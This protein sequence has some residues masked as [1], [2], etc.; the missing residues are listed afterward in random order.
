MRFWAT[1]TARLFLFFAICG[2]ATTAAAQHFEA[3]FTGQGQGPVPLRDIREIA[4]D[5]LNIDVVEIKDPEAV[6]ENEGFRVYAPG[7]VHFGQVHL[8]ADLAS[9]SGGLLSAWWAE[10]VSGKNIRKN[11][12]VTLFRK[13]GTPTRAFELSSLFPETAELPE[14]AA[15]SDCPQEIVLHCSMRGVSLAYLGPPDAP[16]GR[17]IYVSIDDEATGE[18]GSPERWF[19]WSGGEVIRHN[20]VP[21]AGTRYRIYSPGHKS[22]GEVTL[23]GATTG[24]R[25]AMC[26]WITSTVQGRPW[27]RSMELQ[28]ILKDGAAGKQFTYHECFPTRYVFPRFSADQPGLMFSETLTVKIGR[29]ELTT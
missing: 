9:E 11:V 17:G 14:Q 21:L 26:Q 29:I 2:L 19:R 3:A 10:C 25:K 1:W 24:Q 16:Q 22:V 28:E 8:R 20:E 12:T 23:K 15:C 6:R 18:M 27:K 5:D 4:I 7:A 13:D